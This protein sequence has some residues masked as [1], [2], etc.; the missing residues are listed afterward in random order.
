MIVRI[1]AAIAL[2]CALFLSS[3]QQN[4]AKADIL[5]G[6]LGGALLGGLIGGGRGAIGGAI[7]GGVVGGA[8]QA[9]R[10]DRNYYNRNP[11]YRSQMNSRQRAY[12]PA[13]QYRGGGRNAR[14]AQERRERARR[15]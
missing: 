1:F 6:A 15:R 10:N 13:P 9:S 11:R 14:A 4:Q 2:T 8:V 5:G 12:R 7:I 3:V